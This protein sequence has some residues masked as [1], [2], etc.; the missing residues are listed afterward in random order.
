MELDYEAILIGPPKH[1]KTT[2]VRE[3]VLEHLRTYATGLAL[4]HDT[5]RQYLDICACY[6]SVGEFRAAAAAA[7]ASGT[8]LARGASIGGDS[9]PIAE[10]AWELGGIH[11]RDDRVAIPIMLAYDETSMMDSSGSTFI[12]KIDLQINA[13]R[14]HRGI[15]PV[16]N[17]QRLT[18][19]TEAF[20]DMT[21]DV[22][23]FAQ[24]KRRRVRQIEDQ[25]GLEDGTLNVLLGAQKFV[26]VHWKQ[27]EGLV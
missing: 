24:H 10:L 22:Y 15:A 20:Y 5:N 19:L 27:G 17:V 21:T 25:L 16:Y 9:T 13:N 11:N 8:P 2:I 23:V 1:G 3:L 6:E 12:T 14:R 26:H 18:A 4:V 7:G